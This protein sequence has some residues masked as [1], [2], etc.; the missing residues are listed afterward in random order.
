MKGSSLKRRNDRKG[1][2]T[3]LFSGSLAGDLDKMFGC[4]EP[5]TYHRDRQRASPP[6]AAPSSPVAAPPVAAPPDDLDTVFGALAPYHKDR[7]RRSSP[8][9]APPHPQG[10]RCDDKNNQHHDVKRITPTKTPAP[11]STPVSTPT[12][13]SHVRPPQKPSPRRG[14]SPSPLVR[15]NALA[16][17]EQSHRLTQTLINQCYQSLIQS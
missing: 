14:P 15:V 7:R 9:A 1:L 3:S 17:P 12:P 11:V 16:H 2:P 4:V 5:S 13:R 6:V 10:N 8:V